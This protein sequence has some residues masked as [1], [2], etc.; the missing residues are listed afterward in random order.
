M[1]SMKSVGE[2]EQC[3]DCKRWF[4]KDCSKD[5]LESHSIGIYH[6]KNFCSKVR[7]RKR[8][9]IAAID[10]PPTKRVATGQ[11]TDK[12]ETIITCP[13]DWCTYTLLGNGMYNHNSY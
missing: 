12:V 10:T 6:C 4:C 8:H 11:K 1:K 7:E 9:S 13:N 3:D 2:E 5:V